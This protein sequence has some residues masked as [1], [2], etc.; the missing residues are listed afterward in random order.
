[1]DQAPLLVFCDFDGTFSVQD[2]GSTLAKKRL[3]ERR[4]RLWH[5]Y[6]QGDLDPW[7]YCEALFNGFR[8]GEKELD[9]FLETIDL[10][11]GAEAM[12]R[13]CDERGLPFQILSDG[14]DYNIRWLRRRHSVEFDFLANSLRLGEDGEWQIEPGRRNP[15]CD[16]GT[17]VC[18]RGVIEAARARTGAVCV[19]VG[20]GLVSDLCGALAADH[21]FAK[22]SLAPA[23]DER[24]VAYRSFDT[25]HDVVRGLG[26]ILEA[27][28][29]REA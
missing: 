10:D 11:P 8:C 2:V 7:G 23:L 19:H 28:P 17:G 22:D 18:K 21:A 29:E 27:L 15:D 5:R 12:L 26:E 3:P 20:N 14:F 25:L 13:F 4:A 24:S 16:C 1:M 9:A 6:E